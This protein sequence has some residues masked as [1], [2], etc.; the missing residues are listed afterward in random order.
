VKH[1]FDEI[2]NR[3][4]TNS[5]KY[6]LRKK[7]FGTDDVYPL[8]VADT[9]FKAP[10][11]ILNPIRERLDHGILGY[12]L[13]DKGYYQS[14]IDWQDKC[15]GWQVKSNWIKYSPGVV[16]SLFASVLAFTNPG[17]KVIIQTPVYHPFYYAIQDTG[18][19]I[20]KNPLILKDGRYYMD[21]DDLKSKIDEQTKL[22]FI[23]NPHNPTSSVW[24]RKELEDICEICLKNNIIIIS[25]EIHSDIVHKPY[26]HIPTASLS[27][28]ISDRTITLMAPSKTFNIA[29]LN[30]S[31]IISS[32]EKILKQLNFYFEGLHIGPNIFAL[33]ATK[34]AYNNGYDWLQQL[35]QYYAANIKV[36]KEFLSNRLPKIGLIDPEGTFLL[37]LDFRKYGLSQADLNKII[38]EKAK[39]GLSDGTTFGIEGIGFQRLNIGCP[40]KLLTEALFALEGAFKNL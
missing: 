33:E 24:K 32:N 8:W 11:F 12:T 22:I 19:H 20:L 37:W 25:D 23:C 5:Y 1:N 30:S 17:D 28:E 29:G 39:I 21:L 18:R 35:L 26:K 36:V 40:T 2:V 3:K 13:T 10:D 34:A 38:V 14:I 7:I 4:G 6:D 27:E 16:P 31:Y 15:H 9:E